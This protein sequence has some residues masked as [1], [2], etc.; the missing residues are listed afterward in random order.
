MPGRSALRAWHLTR[1]SRA[2]NAR[3]RAQTRLQ[4]R[5][6]T[7]SA[8]SCDATLGACTRRLLAEG[9]CAPWK[10]AA[11]MFVGC[12]PAHAAYFSVY[13]SS[14]AQLS[15]LAGRPN[16]PVGSAVAVA[17]ATLVHDAIMTPMDVVKQRLQLGHHAGMLDCTRHILAAEGWR[18]LYV[19]FGVTLLMNM[20]YALVMGATN[21]WL[22]NALRPDGQHTT[23]TY[24][25][26]GAG[27]GMVAAALTNPLDVAKTR[28]QTQNLGEQPA[29]PAAPAAAPVGSGARGAAS[30]GV[31]SGG[32]A[33][34]PA[35]SVERAA[36]SAANR[37][38]R[39]FVRQLPTAC[40]TDTSRAVP[41]GAPLAAPARLYTGLAQ[42]LQRV[43]AEEG[44]WA[45]ARG[46]GPRVLYHAP[47]VA[48]SWVRAR[49]PA[50]RRAACA[51]PD[52][53]PSRARRH[54]ILPVPRR[55][56]TRL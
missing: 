34:R 38:P 15:E 5:P 13:E 7:C 6:A 51:A 30:G 54:A 44:I 39:K 21:E 19:S 1:V 25:L 9:L 20:P 10:G 2:L 29:A 16:H 48:I 18:A 50:A 52:A 36:L 43:H 17:T 11:T 47:S 53:T 35:S 49:S 24:M 45:F 42:T 23:S 27:A 37:L 3:V 31:A 14:K 12:V 22:R 41:G 33:L 4:A 55:R 46:V 8:S 40:S 56:P 28:L 32:S 26:S